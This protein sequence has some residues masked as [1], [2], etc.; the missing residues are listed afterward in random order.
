MH[1]EYD[2][3]ATNLLLIIYEVIDPCDDAY[4]ANMQIHNARAI[5]LEEL[6]KIED[7]PNYS[8][9]KVSDLLLQH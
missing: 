1:C 6:A 4:H 2:G 9:A 3:V 8:I 7:F 5:P